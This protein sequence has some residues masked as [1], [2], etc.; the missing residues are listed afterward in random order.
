MT[1]R[2]KRLTWR[3]A[4]RALSAIIELIECENAPVQRLNQAANIIREVRDRLPS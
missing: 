1:A 4:D 2:R 3:K